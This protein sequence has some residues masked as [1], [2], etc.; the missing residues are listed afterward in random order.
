MPRE[1]RSPHLSG[2]RNTRSLLSAPAE[3]PPHRAARPGHSAGLPPAE[4]SAPAVSHATQTS[5]VTASPTSPHQTSRGNAASSSSPP[6]YLNSES[7]QEYWKYVHEHPRR[8]LEEPPLLYQTPI[9]DKRPFLQPLCYMP[10][11]FP[12]C[13]TNDY[14]KA[15]CGKRSSSSLSS[16]EAMHAG[17]LLVGENPEDTDAYVM[18]EMNPHEALDEATVAFRTRKHRR[19]ADSNAG[20]LPLPTSN[21]SNGYGDD[22]NE[23]TGVLRRTSQQQEEEDYAA[24]WQVRQQHPADERS[25]WLSATDTVVVPTDTVSSG[26][27]H[28]LQ[29]CFCLRCSI[30]LQTNALFSEERRRRRFPYRFAAEWF[31]GAEGDYRRTL[32]TVLLC[33]LLSGGLFIPCGFSYQGLGTACY[34]WRAR[35]LIRCRYGIFAPAICDFMLMLCLP[36]LS[37]D[38]QGIEMAA[39]GLVEGPGMCCSARMQ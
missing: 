38:Q 7:A 29:R 23:G 28:L 6:P 26:C 39:N 33:D 20:A 35:Y 4:S 25:A 1:E 14:R 2:V 31:F 3:T 15:Y 11:L 12:C 13:M 34:G 9:L 37:V 30:A 17:G 8:T 36:M 22:T 19:R 21:G 10:L 32:L 24:T 18:S 5:D 27:L 16:P